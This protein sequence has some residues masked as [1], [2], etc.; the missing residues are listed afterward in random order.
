MLRR[1]TAQTQQDKPKLRQGRIWDARPLLTLTVGTARTPMVNG[2]PVAVN[3][4]S[5]RADPGSA[6]NLRSALKHPLYCS[7]PSCARLRIAARLAPSPVAPHGCKGSRPAAQAGKY[8]YRYNE[9]NNVDPYQVQV[10]R[11]CSTST[12][13]VP[14]TW[15]RWRISARTNSRGFTKLTI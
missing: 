13:I 11:P 15:Y 1:Q 10:I 8:E 6:S 7:S 4:S 9:Q 14:G 2:L 12:R 5:E 3:G